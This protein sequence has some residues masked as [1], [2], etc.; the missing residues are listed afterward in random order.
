MNSQ[1]LSL[2]HSEINSQE[3]QFYSN[4]MIE[5]I[6][7]NL[8]K[9]K[10]ISRQNFNSRLSSLFE[11]YNSFVIKKI[12]LRKA[13]HEKFNSENSEHV[14][15]LKQIWY[16]LKGNDEIELVDRKWRK[17]YYNILL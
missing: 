11:K 14:S 13:Y 17:Y 15:L 7:S 4:E 6:I 9:V 2:L 12:N 16:V 10:R 1:Q 5:K 3:D 8:I